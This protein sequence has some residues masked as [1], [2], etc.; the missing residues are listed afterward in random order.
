MVG[1]RY[2]STLGLRTVRGRDILKSDGA[3]S[4]KVCIINEG[5]AKQFFAGRNPLGL[6]VTGIDG[7]P[8]GTREVSYEVVGLARNYRSQGLRDDVEARFFMPITQPRGNN[9]KRAL[10]LIRRA[11]ANNA[12][13]ASSGRWTLGC[14]YTM[15]GQWKSS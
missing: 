4:P 12:V 7:S 2:F 6:H 10:F 15:R 3:A 5:F 14:R 9:V 13:L 8:S 1:P 11:A